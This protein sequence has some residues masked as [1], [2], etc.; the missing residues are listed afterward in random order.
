[1]RMQLA[2]VL[3]V[4]GSSVAATSAVA[5]SSESVPYPDGYR[6]WAHVKSAY[7]GPESKSHATFGGLHHVYANE[8]GLRGYQSGRFP[9]G[10]VII[11]DR[12]DVV[13][14]DGVMEEGA[15]ATVDVM[16]KDST[17]FAATGGWGF[18]R[19]RGDTREG[20][21]GSRAESACFQCHA[22]RREHDFVFSALRK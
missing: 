13:T 7:V 19:F 2:G 6:R 11:V 1:M 17:R 5:V 15:R 4:L 16:H 8:P 14:K 18:E 20:I 3:L 10:S 21:I 9:Q 12:L 22:S